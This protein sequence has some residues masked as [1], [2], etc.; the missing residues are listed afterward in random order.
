MWKITYL[1][2]RIHVD[3]TLDTLL[4]AVR[5][6]V[7]AHP[8]PLTFGAPKLSEAPL[9]PLVRRETLSLG[10]CLRALFDVVTLLEAQVA[11]VVRRQLPPLHLLV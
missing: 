5:P 11:K 4:A 10:A 8:L 9:L 6:R 2:V 3:A 7:A 1:F